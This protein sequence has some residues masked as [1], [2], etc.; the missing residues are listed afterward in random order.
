[1]DVLH[2]NLFVAVSIIFIHSSN[3]YQ[4]GVDGTATPA[5]QP[6]ADLF[7]QKHMTQNKGG[8]QL[9]IIT[10]GIPVVTVTATTAAVATGVATPFALLRK[11]RRH[12]LE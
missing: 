1:M 6:A 10:L 7:T 8:L 11:P 5:S 12:M 2:T 9:F 4:K 3:K